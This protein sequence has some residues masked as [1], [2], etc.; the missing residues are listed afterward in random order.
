MRDQDTVVTLVDEY[1]SILKQMA[2]NRV[3]SSEEEMLRRCDWS[4]YAAAHLVRLARENGAFILRNALAL[5]VALN[6]EDGSLGL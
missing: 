5:S 6:I 2:D 3:D 4:P 1:R